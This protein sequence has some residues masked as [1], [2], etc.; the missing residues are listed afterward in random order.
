MNPCNERNWRQKRE[1][2]PAAFIRYGRN[3]FRWRKADK[4]GDLVWEKNA[5]PKN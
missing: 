1:A 5:C 3:F 4:L 2:N